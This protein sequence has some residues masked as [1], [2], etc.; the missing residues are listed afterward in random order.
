MR[1]RAVPA[2]VLTTAVL[3][4]AAA[5]AQGQDG[6]LFR[7]PQAQLTL[8]AGPLLP[9][10]HGPLFDDFTTQLTLERKDFRAPAL[11]A[12]FVVM[13]GNRFDLAVGAGWAESDARSE[14]RDFIGSDDLPIV[15]TTS[16]RTTP[17]TL[18]LRFQPLA[19]GRSVG[20][21]AWLPATLTPYVGGGV[22]ITWYE[23]VQQ[24]EFIDF[25]DDGIFEAY[26]Q[27]KGKGRTM[28]ALAGVDRWFTPRVG[29]NLEARYT[30]GSAALS[31]DFYD[32]RAQDRLDLTAVQAT[33]GLSYRW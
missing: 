28:H 24:G 10:A 21:L 25:R 12:D 6:F 3:L 20:T 7:S 11:S 18:T 23:L 31:G 17:V 32:P 9:R 4:V 2:A 30:R 15:Q 14:Y 13:L 19:R 16:L 26:W 5:P 1:L 29:L 22:G 8:K 33:V 27:S